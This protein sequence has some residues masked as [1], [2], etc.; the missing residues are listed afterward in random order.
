MSLMNWAPF[1]ISPPGEKIASMRPMATVEGLGDR[2]RTAAFAEYQAF[3]AFSWAASH[4]TQESDELRQVWRRLAQDER[5]H[6][7]MILARM[8]ELGV[9]AADK[10]V[11]DRLWLALKACASAAEFSLFMA[12]SEERGRT[13]ELR[14]Y[15]LLLK[16][17]PITAELFRR[18][19]EDEAEH[20][21]LAMNTVLIQVP[22][23]NR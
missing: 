1:V 7:D 5:R 2:L 15:E 19:A 10:P 23:K 11:S 18:I 17:D 16:T 6:R 3:E 22:S 21:A 8:E 20:I 4:F 14:F 9:G 12:R 13:A